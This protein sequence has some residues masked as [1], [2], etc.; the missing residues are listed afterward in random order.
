MK[1]SGLLCVIL[2]LSVI[3]GCSKPEPPAAKAPL[4]KKK[5]AEKKYIA[6]IKTVSSETITTNTVPEPQAMAPVRITDADTGLP[7]THATVRVRWK[8]LDGPKMCSGIHIEDGKYQ[9]P[10]NGLKGTFYIGALADGY[11]PADKENPK[12]PIE[13]TM[14]EGDTIKVSGTI[15]HANG[16]PETN[17]IVNLL[18]KD[19]ALQ[20]KHWQ[21][22]SPCSV[23]P[24]SNGTFIL[25]HVPAGMDEIYVKYDLPDDTIVEFKDQA[26]ST[27]DGDVHLTLQLPPVLAIKGQ[28]LFSSGTTVS[29][30]WVWTE[31]VSREAPDAW[32]KKLA[33][34]DEAVS[35]VTT[36]S[37][38]EGHFELTLLKIM[39]RYI[40]KAFHPL[41]AVAYAGPYSDS[42]PPPDPLEL[43]IHEDG[44]RLYG[45]LCDTTDKPVTN[46]IVEYSIFKRTA[47]N[48]RSGK[49]NK[50]LLD[51]AEDG[52]Y[53]SGIIPPG[54]H[55]LAFT[56][57]G[58]YPLSKNVIIQENLAEQCNVEFLPYFVVTG[59]VCDAE[60]Q[61][62]I[63]NVVLVNKSW[64]GRDKQKISKSNRVKCKAD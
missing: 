24:D 44:A 2:L 25:P 8:S 23:M 11:L 31:R 27:S 40:I 35:G 59:I 28:V 1:L 12:F 26:F 39:D 38:V 13:L 63:P 60:T 14:K 18:M 37:D 57:R 29:G 47:P 55:K 9:V 49:S 19:I 41:Y 36:N 32:N 56:T 34:K 50:L 33:E 54:S 17:G 42:V 22:L 64:R 51:I 52:N 6:K 20:N 62:P 21:L 48:H 15:H 16:N 7:I 4:P 30:A 45:R 5:A 61:E 43:I 46:C 3:S 10:T 53:I 58:H